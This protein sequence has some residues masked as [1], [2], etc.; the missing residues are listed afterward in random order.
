[1]IDQSN[2]PSVLAWST[3]GTSFTINDYKRLELEYLPK[4]FNHSKFSSFQRQLN[5]YGFQKLRGEPDLQVHTDTVRF[6]HEFFLKGRPDLLH[7]IQRSTAQL[8]NP[9]TS[10]VQESQVEAMQQ[11]ITML[12][13]KVRSMERTMDEKVKEVRA[14]VTDEYLAH[15]QKLEASYSAILDRLVQH[16][17]A[18]AATA[19]ATVT[20]NP[21]KHLAHHQSAPW[22]PSTISPF[23]THTDLVNFAVRK[24]HAN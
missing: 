6:S 15:I 11:Q 20:T 12:Q 8:I 16:L 4:Y 24:N 1:M 18:S 10:Q 7:K 3:G 5:F 17:T 19:T 2:D 22:I 9:S 23:M 13:E 21:T 14:S